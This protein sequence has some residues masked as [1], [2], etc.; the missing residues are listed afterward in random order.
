[1]L[2]ARWPPAR[3]LPAPNGHRRGAAR[4]LSVSPPP[5][6]RTALNT[7]YADVPLAQKAKRLAL[8]DGDFAL[9]AGDRWPEYGGTEV[10]YSDAHLLA[11]L[12]S[13]FTICSMTRA[14]YGYPTAG[15]VSHT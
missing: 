10:F 4:S 15:I 3:C 7:T 2:G 8:F 1:P 14:A 12:T 13:M 5:S 9:L 6:G 11:T